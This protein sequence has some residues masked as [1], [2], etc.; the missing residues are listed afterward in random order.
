MERVQFSTTVNEKKLE[1]F[2]AKCKED[3]IPMNEVM[4]AFFD[5]YINGEVSFKRTVTISRV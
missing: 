5:L 3:K 4:E 1:D 2:R